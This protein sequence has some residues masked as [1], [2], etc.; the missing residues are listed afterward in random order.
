MFI[1]VLQAVILRLLQTF[2]RYMETANAS[3]FVWMRKMGGNQK[4][5]VAV[6]CGEG[7]ASTLFLADSMLF[8]LISTS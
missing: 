1:A 7:R 2:R 4:D 6:I 5:L 3:H 8:Y